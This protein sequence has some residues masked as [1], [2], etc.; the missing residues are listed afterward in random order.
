MVTV[1]GWFL[2]LQDFIHANLAE[3]INCHVIQD[4]AGIAGQV[5][6]ELGRAET[7]VLRCARNQ[8]SEPYV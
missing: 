8:Q 3:L 2:S 6:I 5:I 4:H 7:Y 1:Y